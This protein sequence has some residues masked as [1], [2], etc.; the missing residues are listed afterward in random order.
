MSSGRN[1]RAFRKKTATTIFRVL[2]SSSSH[3][4]TE[5]S[6]EVSV[7]LFQSSTLQNSTFAKIEVP[8]IR[9]NTVSRV[10]GWKMTIS[11][12]TKLRT[13]TVEKL[14][15]S[16]NNIFSDFP[17]CSGRFYNRTRTLSSGYRKLFTWDLGRQGVKL[18]D[19]FFS[20]SFKIPF[21][22]NLF[23]TSTT[24]IGILLFTINLGELHHCR[25]QF[26]LW[27]HLLHFQLAKAWWQ[28]TKISKKNAN[29][30]SSFNESGRS[31]TEGICFFFFFLFLLLSSFLFLL[32][33]LVL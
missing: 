8:I 11:V 16:K 23:C 33:L 32:P 7:Y 18:T 15:P 17:K 26:A 3:N 10:W 27:T 12:V 5:S 24:W 21:M 20:R 9:R 19:P 29:Y 4:F 13:M 6:C 31:K 25:V 30:V 1:L 14:I 22:V 28:K 2:D